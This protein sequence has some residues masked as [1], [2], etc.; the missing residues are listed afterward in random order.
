MELMHLV[1]FLLEK[2]SLPFD[3]FLFD[4]GM[5]SLSS[6]FSSIAEVVLALIGE[7]IER[8]LFPCEV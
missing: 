5:F 1:T 2:D 6:C 8:K 7:I 3:D 4:L